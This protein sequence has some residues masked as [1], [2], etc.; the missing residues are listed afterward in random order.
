MGS[1]TALSNGREP[2]ELTELVDAFQRHN[3]VRIVITLDVREHDGKPDLRVIGQAMGA[4]PADADPVPSDSTL[5]T[6]WGSDYVRLMGLF[7]RLLYVLDFR[8]GE[9]E[10]EGVRHKKA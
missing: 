6:L 9:K 8:L 5:S 1:R 10:W 2:E 3:T 4:E 7:T